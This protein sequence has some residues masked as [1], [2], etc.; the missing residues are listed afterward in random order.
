MPLETEGSKSKL[1]WRTETPKTFKNV[2]KFMNSRK[3]TMKKARPKKWEENKKGKEGDVRKGN[4]KDR[5]EVKE[6]RRISPTTNGNRKQTN[7]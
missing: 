5:K 4:R 2:G 3:G 7:G 1:Q 6:E